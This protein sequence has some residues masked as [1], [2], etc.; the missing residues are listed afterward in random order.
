MP[1]SPQSLLERLAF[2]NH[3]PLRPVAKSGTRK[4]LLEDGNQVR[5]FLNSLDIHK[6]MKLDREHPQTLRELTDVIVSPLSYL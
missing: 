6:S 4:T 1:S 2:R 5:E 3:R